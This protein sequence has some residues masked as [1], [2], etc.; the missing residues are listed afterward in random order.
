MIVN[1]PVAV[2]YADLN[3]TIDQWQSGA[4]WADLTSGS[5]AD[6]VP[7]APIIV[8]DDDDAFLAT[9]TEITSVGP[10]LVVHWDR[11][12]ALSTPPHEA[13]HA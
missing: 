5:R 3:L 6:V 4:L 8:T 12:V 13:A 7:G 2:F 9:V 11:R 10:H 1:E